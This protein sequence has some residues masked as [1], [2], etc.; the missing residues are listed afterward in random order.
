MSADPPQLSEAAQAGPAFGAKGGVRGGN[1]RETMGFEPMPIEAQK[2]PVSPLV[3]R[4]RL[5]HCITDDA[6]PSSLRCATLVVGNRLFLFPKG[7]DG[8]CDLQFAMVMDLATLRLWA[9]R[10]MGSLPLRCRSV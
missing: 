9:L 4:L 6:V 3:P 2:G 5:K 10:V 8:M 1:R 7:R